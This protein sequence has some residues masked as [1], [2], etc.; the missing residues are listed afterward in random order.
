VA[1][2]LGLKAFFMGVKVRREVGLVGPVRLEAYLQVF[3]LA[4]CFGE[5][6]ELSFT[7]RR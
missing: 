6:D 4:I 5:N 7:V 3:R 2:R 1:N